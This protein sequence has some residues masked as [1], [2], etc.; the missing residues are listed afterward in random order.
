LHALE[1]P[2]G[3]ERRLDGHRIELGE[4]VFPAERARVQ[5]I[6]QLSD[7]LRV[8]TD[9]VAPVFRAELNRLAAGA[10][11]TNFLIVLASSRT[12]SILRARNGAV[13]GH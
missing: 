9:E 6:A 3:G 13:A 5:A 7:R 1:G 11:I 4:S 12:R 10:H 2:V 8:G